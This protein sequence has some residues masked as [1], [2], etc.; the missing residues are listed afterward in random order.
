MPLER[1]DL[2]YFANDIKTTIRD[3]EGRLSSRLEKNETQTNKHSVAIAVLEN[4][5][6]NEKSSTRNSAVGWGGSA[7]AAI[8]TALTILWH[9]FSGVK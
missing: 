9:Y 2:E 4:E 7:G 5:K 1:E 8:G 6:T 3:V